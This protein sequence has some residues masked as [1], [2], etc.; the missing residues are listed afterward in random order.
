MDFNSKLFFVGICFLF[1]NFQIKAQEVKTNADGDKIVVYADGTWRYLEPG[2]TIET[3]STEQPK[4]ETEPEDTENEKLSVK[5]KDAEF[6][7]RINAVR[8]S[9]KKD[10]AAELAQRRVTELSNLRVDYEKQLADLRAGA[11]PAPEREEILE[12]KILTTREN[13]NKARQTAAAATEEAEFYT[14]LIQMSDKKRQKTL[15]KYLEEK[16]EEAAEKTENIAAQTSTASD[17]GNVTRPKT[18]YAV[19]NPRTDVILNPPKYQCENIT[20]ETDEFTGK[21]RRST[22]PETFFTYTR[23][24]IRPY[25]KGREHTV[26]RA[27]VTSMSGGIYV[28]S[29]EIDIASRTAQQEYGGIMSNGTLMVILLDGSTVTMSNSRTDRGKFDA[30]RDVYT[31]KGN[32]QIPPKSVD[33]LRE[34]EIDKVRVVWEQG[35]DTYDIY[36][37]DFL[38]NHLG[39]VID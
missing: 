6:T 19:Y 12:R 30:V 16:R 26:C 23:P 17:N 27:S 22:E 31:F 14:S 29:L 38:S 28:V 1:L 36:N 32:Y 35:Y 20:D 37:M 24:E 11:V 10:R 9:E 34:G 33:D 5:E 4:A 39:C 21:R 25:Y 13:E 8:Q 15:N 3:K 2:E 7:A 18:A